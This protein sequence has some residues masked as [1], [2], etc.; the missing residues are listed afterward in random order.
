MNN[1]LWNKNFCLVTAATVLGSA[2]AIAGG[3]ALSFFIYDETKSTLA[4]ALIIAI[5]LIPTTIVPL[6]IS[7]L[8]DRL[9][10]K[11]FLVC[12][13]IVNGT[14][15]AAMGIWLLFNSF[16][17]IGYLVISFLLAC[18]D[19]VD[20]LAYTSIYPE[21]IPKGEEE[22][23]YSVSSMLYPILQVIMMPAAGLLLD[24]IGVPNLLIIQS[25]LSFSAAVTESFIKI[26]KK[27]PLSKNYSIKLWVND[28]KEALLYLK[29]EKG[30][31]SIF[32][33]MAV[34]NGV[35]MG[36][37]P[38]LIAFFRTASGFSAGIYSFFSVAEFAG[39]TLGSMVQYKIKIPDTKKYGFVFLVYQIYETMDMCLLWLPYPPMLVNRGICGFLGNNSA[40]IRNAAV[41]RYIPENLRSRVNAFDGI[42][43]T[44]AGGLLTL[45]V[46]FLGEVLDYRQ[47]ITLC[48]AIAITAS[49]MLILGRKKEV[50]RIY[51][52]R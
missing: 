52:M 6:F 24:K 15:Y 21:L 32:E 16:S 23:G 33:Y 38:V 2:G 36:F 28:I 25:A 45:L 29:K 4:S 1:K 26:E 39:R 42:L 3:F 22:K 8:M 5:R 30:L 41:Q 47:C 31:R 48:G 10:R 43:G 46:G 19:S 17:Y 34:T 51:V 40:I 20:E 14:V 9:P 37:S 13:D 50:K 12:G 27:Q 49:W 7:P 11:A 18:L 35:A 44:A